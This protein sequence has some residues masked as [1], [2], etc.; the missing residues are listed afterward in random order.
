VD[1][2]RSWSRSL[3]SRKPELSDDEPDATRR[4]MLTGV[5]AAVAVGVLAT[6]LPTPALAGGRYDDDDDDDDDDHGRRRSRDHGRRRSR[7]EHWRRRSGDH[8]RRRSRRMR[9]DYDEDR[10]YFFGPVIVCE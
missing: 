7:R 9:R 2:T 8:G 4:L 6:A 10:C 3:F 5:A 1:R